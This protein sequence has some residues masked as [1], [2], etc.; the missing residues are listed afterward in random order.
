MVGVGFIPYF[1]LMAFGIDPP[2]V[3]FGALDTS[4]ALTPAFQFFVLVSASMMGAVAWM[5]FTE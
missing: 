2:F 1:L 4:Y 3:G 5:E